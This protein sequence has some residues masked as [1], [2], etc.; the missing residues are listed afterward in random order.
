MG[1]LA[2][3]AASR[4]TGDG[5]RTASIVPPIHRLRAVPVSGNSAHFLL[6][7]RL[8]TTVAHR[9]PTPRPVSRYLCPFAE[10]LAICQR[11]LQTRTCKERNRA[12]NW[13]EPDALVA[14][15]SRFG[16]VPALSAADG[17]EPGLAGGAMVAVGA[18]PDSDGG[19][20]AA[21]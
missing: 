6:G 7:P 11:T 14:A 8:S 17:P 18:D 1:Q 19:A 16:H 15:A 5:P 9:F 13:Q 2:F 3:R 4:R 20:G 12:G 10:A 21:G